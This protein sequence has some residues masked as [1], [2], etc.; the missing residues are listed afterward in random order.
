MALVCYKPPATCKITLLIIFKC[1]KN[2]KNS[3]NIFYPNFHQV[4]E[5]I[6]IK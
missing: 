1:F 2:S 6:W 4:K 5:N 3:K